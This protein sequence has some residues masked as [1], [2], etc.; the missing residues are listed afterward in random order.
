M[1]VGRQVD[2]QVAPLVIPQGVSI[3]V[4]VNRA[5]TVGQLERQVAGAAFPVSVSKATAAHSPT[6]Q[7]GPG[8][9]AVYL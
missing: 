2:S 5:L 8:I 1:N 7:D 6:Y 9:F 3:V 4:P